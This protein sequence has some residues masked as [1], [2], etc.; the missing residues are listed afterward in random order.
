MIIDGY[1]LPPAKQRKRTRSLSSVD[2]TVCGLGIPDPDPDPEGL[3]E[4]P[5]LSKRQRSYL[6]TP[7]ESTSMCNPTP[8]P[9]SNLSRSSAT[10]IRRNPQQDGQ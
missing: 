4:G 2:T 9:N 1:H 8:N 3:H 10:G 7:D 6:H 5:H